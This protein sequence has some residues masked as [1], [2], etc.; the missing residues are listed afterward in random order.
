MKLL[1]RS[2][3]LRLTE[4]TTESVI[5]QLEAGAESAPVIECGARSRHICQ[6]VVHGGLVFIKHGSRSKFEGLREWRF[7]PDPHYYRAFTREEIAMIGW[8]S[9]G[10]FYVEGK[11]E[12][13]AP[14]GMQ[15]QMQRRA[16]RVE[17]LSES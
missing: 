12:N 5:L 14:L 7:L 9:F 4:V 15:K 8:T 10:S 16:S 13:F 6:Y 3:Y 2:T 17:V 1:N 11:S